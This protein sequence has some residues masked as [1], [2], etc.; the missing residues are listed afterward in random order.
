MRRSKQ[1]YRNKL[2]KPLKKLYDAGL[3]LGR[4]RQ[5][6]KLQAAKGQTPMPSGPANAMQQQPQRS[7]FQQGMEVSP[8]N[9]GVSQPGQAP[10]APPQEPEQDS[11]EQ[12]P[13]PTE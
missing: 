10:A 13:T 2:P 3:K 11:E 12:E 7:P 1:G 4:I 9:L 6:K 5:G 8:G